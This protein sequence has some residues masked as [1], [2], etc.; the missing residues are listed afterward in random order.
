[1]ARDP[2]RRQRDARRRASCSTPS[3]RAPRRATRSFV[4]D[5]ARRTSP[6]RG[7]VIYDEAVRDAAQVPRRPGAVSSCARAA[8]RRRAR[9]ATPTPSRRPSTPS[10]SSGPTRSSSRPTPR[11]ARAGCARDLV[12]RV[13]RRD[14]P[15]GRARRRRPRRRGPALRRVTLV[16][17]NK[18]VGGDAAARAAQGEGRRRGAARSSSSSSRRRAARA[19][20]RGRR[21][22]ASRRMLDRLH[23]EGLLGAGHDR[24]PR[25]LHGGHERA[26]A[27]SASTRSSSPRCPTSARAGCAPI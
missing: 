6:R 21:A 27:A 20:R 19:T 3:A 15:A 12:E 26:A 4:R 13:Q 11:R 2:R 7:L 22:R 24:R 25:P 1:M 5:R 9:S 16:V 17:A 8:S 10:P 18:T 14:R 23:S